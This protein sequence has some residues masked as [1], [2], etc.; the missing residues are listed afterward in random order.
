MTLEAVEADTVRLTCHERKDTEAEVGVRQVA[1]IGVRYN[2]HLLVM[3]D[4]RSGVLPAAR[5][6]PT[7]LSHYCKIPDQKQH[8]VEI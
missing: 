2:H 7:C 8:E 1:E 3:L 6:R 4:R 5:V